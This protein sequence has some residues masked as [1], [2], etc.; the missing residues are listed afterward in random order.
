MECN[1]KQY[2]GVFCMNNFNV[3]SEKEVTLTNKEV[4]PNTLIMGDC[5][6]VM[7]H[8]PGGSVDLILTDPPYG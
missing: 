6:E 3:L 8:I 7:K 4:M 1:E 5:L 2:K